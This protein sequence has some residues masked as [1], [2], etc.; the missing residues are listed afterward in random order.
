M[1]SPNKGQSGVLE[2]ESQKIALIRQISN[3]SSEDEDDQQPNFEDRQ[4]IQ[5][6]EGAME[7]V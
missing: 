4:K 1:Q 7:A 3:V 2:D 6:A 5:S